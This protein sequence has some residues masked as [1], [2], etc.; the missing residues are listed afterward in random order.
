MKLVKV[1][2]VAGFLLTGSFQVHAANQD[3]V[4]RFEKANE[5]YNQAVYD[6]AL[7]FYHAIEE[8]GFTSDRLLYNMGNTY[9]KLKDYPHAILYYE[10]ALKLNPSDEAIRHNLSIANNMIV[11][12]IEAMPEIFFKVWWRTFYTLFPADTWAWISVFFFS[13]SLLL[14]FVYLTSY[15]IGLRKFAFFAGLLMVFLFVG[16]LDRKSVV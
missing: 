5:W 9:F 12:K 14:V 7:M 1:L 4:N 15:R 13:L 16:S 6:S 10:K 8:A 3:L 11:D 2:I